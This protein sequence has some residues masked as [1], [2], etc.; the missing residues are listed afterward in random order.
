MIA[1]CRAHA[2]AWAAQSSAW[3]W[4]VSH[5]CILCSSCCSTRVAA[6]SAAWFNLRNSSAWPAVGRHSGM[7]PC[8]GVHC[9]SK[10]Y[11]CLRS[12]L[13]AVWKACQHLWRCV[14]WCHIK[15]CMAD[16]LSTARI[17]GIRTTSPGFT[18]S[19]A[20]WDGTMGKSGWGPKV[21]KNFRKLAA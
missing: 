9:M 16:L 21:Q 18:L 4:V 11:P 12:W 20:T 10:R 1:T 6:L 5:A 8:A 14:G 17:M 15:N 13:R 3:R 19:Q 7:R 2:S